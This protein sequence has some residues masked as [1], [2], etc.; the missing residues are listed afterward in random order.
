MF[1]SRKIKHFHIYLPLGYAQLHCFISLQPLSSPWCSQ[2][3]TAPWCC[4]HNKFYWSKSKLSSCDQPAHFSGCLWH[5]YWLGDN[6][7]DICQALQ[8]PVVAPCFWQPAL[9]STEPRQSSADLCRENCFLWN[10]HSHQHLL[11]L[12]STLHGAGAGAEKG[13]LEQLFIAHT[14]SLN[15]G[16]WLLGVPSFQR[17]F[18][19]LCFLPCLCWVGRSGGNNIEKVILVYSWN[20]I[21]KS[22]L[23]TGPH[24]L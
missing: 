4:R 20:I 17:T 5:R 21:M 12:K 9:P 23:S 2:G 22:K 7:L 6:C 14:A 13:E 8:S 19:P 24:C 10:T 3:S 16:M 1:H 15:A 18:M 11:P